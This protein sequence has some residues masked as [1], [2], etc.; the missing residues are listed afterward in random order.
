MAIASRGLCA[1]SLTAAGEAADGQVISAV[2]ANAM[3]VGPFPSLEGQSR[4]PPRGHAFEGKHRYPSEVHQGVVRSHW[5]LAPLFTLGD[6]VPI[7]DAVTISAHGVQQGGRHGRP[8][9][10]LRQPTVR[11]S[12]LRCTAG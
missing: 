8:I 11:R 4:T 7:I 10:W 9:G 2:R 6:A 12:P 5:K 1:A 3:S